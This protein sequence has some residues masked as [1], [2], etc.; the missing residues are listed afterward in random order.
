MKPKRLLVLF[1]LLAILVGSVFAGGQKDVREPG[2]YRVAYVART[3][4]DSFASWLLDSAKTIAEQEYPN[5]RMD[6]FDGQN[7][8][9]LVNDHIENAIVNKYD[10]VLLHPNDPVAHLQPIHEAL[11]A[12]MVVVAVNTVVNSDRVPMVDADPYEQGAVNARYAVDVIPRNAKVV[13]LLG[14]A[15][16]V[17]SF[18]RHRA[19]REEFFDK[20]P[21]VTILDTQIGNWNKEEGL[22]FMED[23]IQAYGSEIAAIVS[24]NDN[25]ALGALEAYKGSSLPRPLAFAV[26]GTADGALAIEEGRLTSTSLQSAYD[27]A[28]YS[29]EMVDDYLTGRK[30]DPEMVIVPNPLYTIE[31]VEGL[32]QIHRDRGIIK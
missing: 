17:H 30:V 24:M 6:F 14:P 22:Q 19:W 10:A 4:G 7:K 18:E 16:N 23:W 25:M 28:K 32:L 9:D 29:V 20:R 31:N 27:L 13:V 21:D 26:D 12:G 11:D 15:G 8:N 3:Q 2:V 5:M 1:L